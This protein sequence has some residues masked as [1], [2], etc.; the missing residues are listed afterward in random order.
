MGRVYGGKGADIAYQVCKE[1]GAKLIYAGQGSLADMG[2]PEIPGQIEHVGYAGLEK[3]KQLLSRAK[4][5]FL[6]SGYCEPFGGAAVE[7][8]LSGTP[9]ISTDWGV[10]NETILHGAT[11]YRCRTFDQF[12][13]AAKNIHNI[14]PQHCRD[15]AI[16]NYNLDRVALMYEEY[17]QMVMDVYTGAGWYQ[18][19]PERTELDWLNRYYPTN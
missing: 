11:G 8:M 16:N 1:I 19:H 2:L 18:A 14:N 15:W 3:R 4:G 6:P 7:A 12:C 17:F 9:V 10:F 5:F 13:W